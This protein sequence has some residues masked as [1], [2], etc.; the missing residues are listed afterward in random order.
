[1]RYLAEVLEF[2]ANQGWNPGPRQGRDLCRLWER[3]AAH[4]GDA[5]ERRRLLILALECTEDFADVQRVRQQLADVE[6]MM[7]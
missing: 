4:T 5:L 3:L 7:R 1:V 6:K 2:L